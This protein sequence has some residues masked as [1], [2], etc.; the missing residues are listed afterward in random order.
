MRQS[1]MTDTGYRAGR[2]GTRLV[3]VI[4]TLGALLLAGCGSSEPSYYTLSPWPGV[5]QPGG[6]LTVKV[7][8]PTIAAYLDRDYIVRNDRGYKLK[9]ADDAAW[10]EPLADMI[11]RT[12]ALDL[13]QRLP[14]SNVFTQTGAI[15][16]EA[17]ATVELDISQ[18]AED[19]DG[20]AEV[21]ATLSVQR[22]DSGP[23]SARVIH[24]VATPDGPAIAQL[25]ASLSQLLGQV[26]DEAAREARAIGPVPVAPQSSGQTPLAPPG[27]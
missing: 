19:H 26:A 13:Q 24:V 27:S 12:L 6:P 2:S 15:S 20:R 10:G 3:A 5:A 7:R 23:S 22:S 25:A 4:G 9:L 21:T 11:G 18:F 8:S 17:Q 16:T 1:S 14:G